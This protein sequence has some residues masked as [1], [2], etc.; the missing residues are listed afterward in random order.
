[1]KYISLIFITLLVGCKLQPKN[2][3]I[4]DSNTYKTK[5]ERIT[6]LKTVIKVPTEIYDSEFELFNVNGFSNNR[7]S[8]P[9]ASSWNYK[10]AVKVNPAEVDQWTKGLIKMDITYNGSWQN[11]IIK[12]RKEEW[13]VKSQPEIYI[14][15]EAQITVLIYRKEGILFKNIVQ[16]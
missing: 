2:V 11:Q 4:L 14:W 15:E 1:M 7:M 9:G 8:I 16:N 13:E 6:I 10:Y 3:T 12:H 5:E